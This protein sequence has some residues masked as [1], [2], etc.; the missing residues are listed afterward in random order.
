MPDLNGMM[1][2]VDRVKVDNRLCAQ[3]GCTSRASIIGMCNPHIDQFLEVY[4]PGVDS[5]DLLPEGYCYLIPDGY[6]F[7]RAPG[8]PEANHTGWAREHRKVWHDEHGPIPDDYVVHHIDS[9][10]ANN[11]ATNLQALSHAQHGRAHR[12]IA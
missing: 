10:R 4:V 9:N 8:H 2:A 7:I 5:Y 1:L 12:L 3:V 6:V 11:A